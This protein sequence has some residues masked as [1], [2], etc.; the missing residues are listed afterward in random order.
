LRTKGAWATL[1]VACFT[2]L[3]AGPANAIVAEDGS[4]QRW[5]SASDTRQ[6]EVRAFEDFLAREG[7]G[8]VLPTNQILLNDDLWAECHKDAP[9]TL[10]QK[11][12]WPHIVSTLRYVRDVVVP[13]IG[14]VKVVSGYRDSE[15]N[16]CAG[17]ASRSAHAGFYALDLVP[18]QAVKYATM[19]QR[20]CASHAKY[21]A[22]Y[23]TGLGFYEGQRFHVDSKGFRRWGSNYHAATSPCASVG[24]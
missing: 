19:V 20:L 18:V 15:L 13:G 5:L 3:S 17:G 10:A 16:R 23:H 6:T 12:Y 22:T 11:A 14:P 8:G 7:V 1:V 24:V 9:Y 4:Y 2:S 21:G